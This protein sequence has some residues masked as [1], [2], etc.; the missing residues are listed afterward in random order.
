MD[1]L[2]DFIGHY[3]SSDITTVQYVPNFFEERE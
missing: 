1:Q 3:E 2:N